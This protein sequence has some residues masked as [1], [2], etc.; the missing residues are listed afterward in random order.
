MESYPV[1]G[2]PHPSSSLSV[3]VSLISLSSFGF[4]PTLFDSREWE[5]LVLWDPYL[6]CWDPRTRLHPGFCSRCSSSPGH[7]TSAS[8]SSVFDILCRRHCPITLL[9]ALWPRVVAA[10]RRGCAQPIHTR[11]CSFTVHVYVHVCFPVCVPL[12]LC[13]YVCC[14]FIKMLIT[15]SRLTLALFC[16]FQ[17]DTL[18]LEDLHAFI[19]QALCLQ[20]KSTSQ[21]MNLQVWS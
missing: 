15:F 21:L 2:S 9:R 5:G 18:S 4:S 1:L 19:A 16:A 20:G 3:C 17:V 11:H 10:E 14:T 8:G 7:L 13:A 6:C 12:C